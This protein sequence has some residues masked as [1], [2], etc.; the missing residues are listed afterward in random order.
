MDVG[1]GVLGA[2]PGAP[3]SGNCR[4]GVS[5]LYKMLSK[6]ACIHRH[7]EMV[8]TECLLQA[9]SGVFTKLTKRRVIFT[10]FSVLLQSEKNNAGLFIEE[11]K[12]K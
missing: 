11:K 2:L 3:D 7:R 6:S 8:F 1:V 12:K 5:S 10:S 9:R 4:I